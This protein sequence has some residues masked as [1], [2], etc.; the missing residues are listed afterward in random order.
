MSSLPPKAPPSRGRARLHA[1]L[2]Q[3]EEGRDLAPVVEDALPLGVEAEPPVRQ[4]LGERRLGLEEEV[5]DPLR[6]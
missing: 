3:A 4:R 5:L 1:L 6:R 2:G